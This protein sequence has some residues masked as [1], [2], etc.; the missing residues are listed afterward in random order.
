MA[1][2]KCPQCNRQVSDKAPACPQCGYPVAQVLSPTVPSANVG[3]V[4]LGRCLG[5]W[6]VWTIWFFLW[7]FFDSGDDVSWVLKLFLG[8][9]PTF[10]MTLWN[11]LQGALLPSMNVYSEKTK[12]FAEGFREGIGLTVGWL[13]FIIVGAGLIWLVAG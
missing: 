5:A 3:A 12:T 2:I 6:S 7:D 11:V 8:L 4:W 13:A 1:L 10:V 9:I